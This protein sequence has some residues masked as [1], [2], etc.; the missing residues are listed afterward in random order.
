MEELKYKSSYFLLYYYGK[1]DNNEELFIFETN[2]PKTYIK[3]F[4]NYCNLTKE[5][6]SFGPE[7]DYYKGKGWFSYVFKVANSKNIL[8]GN[9]Q[10]Y[11]IDGTSPEELSSIILFKGRAYENIFEPIH[12]IDEECKIS[13]KRRYSSLQ[14]SYLYTKLKFL[15]TQMSNKNKDSEIFTDNSYK[16]NVIL[17][18]I[19]PS[20]PD[21]K[22]EF[23]ILD[24]V[25]DYT[26]FQ[27]H[28]FS[29]EQ[30][31]VLVFL[32]R[33]TW[34]L[35]TPVIFSQGSISDKQRDYITQLNNMKSTS[36]TYKGIK[37][38]Y[39]KQ[40]DFMLKFLDRD[41]LSLVE[42]MEAEKSLEDFFKKAKGCNIKY[43]YAKNKLTI[44]IDKNSKLEGIKPFF[45]NCLDEYMM[46]N[47]NKKDSVL[48]KFLESDILCLSDGEKEN[49]SM[50]TAIYEQ[51]ILQLGYKKKYIILFDEIER[52]MHPEMCRRLVSD[53]ISFLNSYT[54]KEF[55]I[56]IASHSP[57]IAGDIRKESII[58]LSRE[59]DHTIASTPEINTFGQNIHTIL[60]RQFFLERTFGEHA[61][62]LINLIVDCL[63]KKDLN[64]AKD[65]INKYLDDEKKYPE[66]K[67]VT[68]SETAFKY[69][70]TSIASIGEPVIRNQMQQR[71]E[72]EF[73]DKLDSKSK[74]EYYEKKIKELKMMGENN[75]D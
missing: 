66:K 51:V 37:K 4:E 62:R 56:I 14:S 17:T 11:K 46:K 26:E 20:D 52:C 7:L 53:L 60:K 43:A 41:D 30:K 1:D 5:N 70:E 10:N 42:F 22:L 64:F 49:L 40:I 54:D 18:D 44:E 63:N 21:N 34:Y 19:I 75:N 67:F 73:S 2:N 71:L 36:V 13:I 35:F 55:Q 6:N 24:T 59:K 28:K 32:N 25:K 9:T 33:F 57:F 23:D 38:L 47:L 61:I 50:F 45:D 15:I 31:F 72:N 3:I 27:I 65:T 74:I 68:S 8:L 29:E 48:N 12:A 69:L 58:C 39:H 16:I